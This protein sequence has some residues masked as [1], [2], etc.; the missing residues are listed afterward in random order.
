MYTGMPRAELVGSARFVDEKNRLCCEVVFGRVA[1]QPNEPLLQ[2]SD[3]F[4]ATLYEFST[5]QQPVN[6]AHHNVSLGP[7]GSSRTHAGRLNDVPT[8]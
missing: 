4:S 1:D 7:A 2:R 5:A 3:S 8:P 6:G